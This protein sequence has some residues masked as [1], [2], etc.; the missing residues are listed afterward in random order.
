MFISSA[1][2]LSQRSGPWR[3]CT[4]EREARE[5]HPACPDRARAAPCSSARFVE[6]VLGCLQNRR[7]ETFS[8]PTIDRSKQITCLGL[9]ALVAP[10]T[11]EADGG[12]QFEGSRPLSARNCK[13]PPI[14]LLGHLLS[15][16]RSQKIAPQPIHLSLEGALVSRLDELQSLAQSTQ[17]LS[18]LAELA[19]LPILGKRG[20]PRPETPSN[21]VC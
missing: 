11:G 18:R 10:K 21:S 15:T 2:R 3:R 14:I 20:R 6:Q 9:L 12:T 8:E 13:S 17:A 4:P 7:I 1:S 16:G 19:M 5:P